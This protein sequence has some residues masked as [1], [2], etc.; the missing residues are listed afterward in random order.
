[1]RS[2]FACCLIAIMT[3]S[4]T[5]NQSGD[6][7]LQDNTKPAYTIGINLPLSGNGSY[8]AEEY[9]KGMELAFDF[10]NSSQRV[11]IEA[12]FEDNKMNPMDAVTITKRFIEIDNVD[13]LVCGYTPIIQATIGISEQN[14][15]PALAV[16]SSAA[17]IASSYKW[18]FRDFGL[19]SQ[20]MP[21][22]ADH[23]YSKMGLRK[24]SWLVVNDD[25]GLDAVR[26]FNKKFNTLGGQLHEG[27]TF[28]ATELDLRN[29]I[30]K[31]MD[32]DPEFIIVIGRG[33]AM[34]NACRQIRERNSGIP[35]FGTNSMDNEIL[36]NALG[37]QADN[38]WYASLYVDYEN[39]R[40]Q[41]ANE[42]FRERYGYDLNWLN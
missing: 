35:I 27:E 29:K 10:A 25:M 14:G 31:V 13:L 18:V 1:M 5:N 7:K 11:S 16:I 30:N 41:R 6:K 32:N 37:E 21:L 42:R 26:F 23:A 3:F 36:W 15:I 34:M 17:N 39:Q 9:K 28:E 33:A 24:G 2:K 38:I 12:L 40:Y 4:C 20:M 8:F 22:L 19:E